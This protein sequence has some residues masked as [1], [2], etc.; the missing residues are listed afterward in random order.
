LGFLLF[1]NTGKFFS[2]L[3]PINSLLSQ[4]GA[5]HFLPLPHRNLPLS[6]FAIVQVVFSLQRPFA[7]V[8]PP[9]LALFSLLLALLSAVDKIN[10]GPRRM[11]TKEEKRRTRKKRKVGGKIA[12]LSLVLSSCT[13]QTPFI[14]RRGCGGLGGFAHNALGRPPIVKEC[15]NRTVPASCA[16]NR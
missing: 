2:F 16:N 10:R 6:L 12:N 5:P 11:G 4:L 7:C 3:F 14:L 13:S 9:P 1:L 8:F 15:T